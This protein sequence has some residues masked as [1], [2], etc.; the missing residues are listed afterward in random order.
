MTELRAPFDGVIGL[1]Q[2]SVGAYA[3]PST[4]IAKLTKITP[5]KVEFG[6]PERYARQVKKGTN[7]DFYDHRPA[8]NLGHKSMQQNHALIPI[9]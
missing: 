6:I 3:S 7:L 1:R 8:G 2:V 4:V 5:L 9:H